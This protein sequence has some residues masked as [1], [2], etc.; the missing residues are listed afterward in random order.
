MNGSWDLA[1]PAVGIQSFPIDRSGEHSTITAFL[2]CFIR[3]RCSAAAVMSACSCY[4]GCA[5]DVQWEHCGLTGYIK[6]AAMFHSASRVYPGSAVSVLWAVSAVLEPR[7]VL[8][9]SC[10][11]STGRVS[12]LGSVGSRA[13]LV[14]IVWAV[15]VLSAGSDPPMRGRW[16]PSGRGALISDGGPLLIVRT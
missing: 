2:A 3:V 8:N 7:Y 6:G 4:N 10:P 1:P 9:S 16:A 12:R 13:T 15:G 14:C 11:L 5:C